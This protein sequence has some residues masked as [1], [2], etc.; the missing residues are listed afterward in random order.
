MSTSSEEF[1]KFV[2]HLLYEESKINIQNINKL[3]NFQ[4]ALTLTTSNNASTKNNSS[5]QSK[6]SIPHKKILYQ[7]NSTH[8]FL[9][10]HTNNT[11]QQSNA[12]SQMK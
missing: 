1:R 8:Q 6:T 3:T 2:N 10:Q 4:R 12:A 9:H 11:K 5:K 7:Y